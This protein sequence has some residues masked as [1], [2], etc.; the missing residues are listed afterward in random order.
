MDPGQTSLIFDEDEEVKM[1]EF[2]QD[3]SIFRNS[4]LDESDRMFFGA[5]G[6]AETGVQER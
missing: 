2:N 4:Q 5:F 6:K 3:S 1:P